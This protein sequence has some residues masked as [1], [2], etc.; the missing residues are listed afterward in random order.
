L[1]AAEPI[2]ISQSNSNRVIKMKLSLTSCFLV[3]LIGALVAG[4]GSEERVTATDNAT[5]DDIAAYEAAIAEAEGMDDA[6]LEA[7][8]GGDEE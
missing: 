2:T 1:N 6:D 3:L 7:D 8:A 4:C 5:A